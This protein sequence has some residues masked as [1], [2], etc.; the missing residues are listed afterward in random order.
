M[1]VVDPQ[2]G[3]PL[4]PGADGILWVRGPN[5]MKGYANGGGEVFRDGWYV[6]GDQARI[7]EDGFLTVYYSPP[8]G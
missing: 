5:V 3:K 4:P 7:D 6:T 8:Q 2:T 1:R